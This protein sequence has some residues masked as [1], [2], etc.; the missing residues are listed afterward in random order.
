MKST[1]RGLVAL[2]LA[3]ALSLAPAIAQE[4]AVPTT[5]REKNSYM[6]GVDV[7]TSIRAVGPD[8]DRAE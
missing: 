8:M 1:L 4:N 3:A 5:E 2:S 7:G 6:V